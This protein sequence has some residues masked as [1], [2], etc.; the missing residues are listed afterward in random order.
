[1]ISSAIPTDMRLYST[2]NGLQIVGDSLE[3]VRLLPDESVDLILTSPPFA[4][5]REKIYGNESQSN[6]GE[7]L[8]QFG[9]AAFR[10]LKTTGSFVIDL[11]GAYERGRPVRSL[12]NYRV[13][14]DFCDNL[15]YRLAEEFF[16]YN[17]ARLPSPIEWVNKRKLRAK[18][19][20]DTVWWFSK[21]DFPKAD[22]T[23]VLVPYSARM[24]TLLKDADKFYKPKERPSGHDISKAFAKDNG[25]AIPSNLLQISNTDSNSEYLRLCKQFGV[26]RHPARFPPELPEFFIKFLTDPNDVVMDIFSGSNT[27]GWVAERLN[28][29]WIS[30]EKDRE[31]AISSGLRFMEHWELSR[32]EQTIRTMREGC[33]LPL[34]TI[35]PE[36]ELPFTL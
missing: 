5:L 7:W 9:R 20:V 34:E 14:L 26:E 35:A 22:V 17:P 27:C 19:A 29:R 36:R 21:N 33:N 12:Y 30:I 4:L 23:R 18:D 28:R 8:S 11:G 1:M 24:N 10:V 3:V 2:R 25:G 13:L 32:I 6:Y 16:W 15:D 31:Y